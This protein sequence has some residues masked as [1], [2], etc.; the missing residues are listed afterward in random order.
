[1]H[2]AP[3]RHR[4]SWNL[5]QRFWPSAVVPT[6]LTFHL[7]GSLALPALFPL[8]PPPPPPPLLLLTRVASISLLARLMACSATAARSV[9]VGWKRGAMRVRVTRTCQRR[10]S[11]VK[12]CCAHLSRAEPDM[13]PSPMVD[14]TQSSTSA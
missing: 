2:L 6:L 9:C 14:A 1:M 12:I 10:N 4:L 7:L 5:M 3:R 11:S 13:V 8:P